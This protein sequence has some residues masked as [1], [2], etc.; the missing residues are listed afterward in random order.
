MRTLYLNIL[1]ISLFFN[2][3]MVSASKAQQTGEKSYTVKCK[4]WDCLEKNKNKYAIITGTFRKY[5][6]NTTGKG[7]N[8]MYWDWELLLTDGFAV[9]VKNGDAK[10]NY[11]SF[12]GKKVLVRGAIFYGIVIGNG[13]EQSATGF[14]IDPVEIKS[15]EQ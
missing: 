12:E 9:P 6:P 1:L 13:E 14:R 5:T 3:F 4:T 2:I 8:Y 11:K 15:A 10:M 7:A